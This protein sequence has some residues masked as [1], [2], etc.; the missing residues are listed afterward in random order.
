MIL[1]SY[2]GIIRIRFKVEGF[3]FLSAC[4]TSSPVF[5]EFNYMPPEF[6]NQEVFGICG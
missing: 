2:D 4:L 3:T 1:T 5:V 6:K